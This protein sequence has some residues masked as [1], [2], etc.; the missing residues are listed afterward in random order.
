[1]ITQDKKPTKGLIFILCAK[2]IT[3]QNPIPPS[4]KIPIFKKKY[5]PIPPYPWNIN[6]NNP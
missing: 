2:K 1:L 4:N 5:K 3:Q 6:L